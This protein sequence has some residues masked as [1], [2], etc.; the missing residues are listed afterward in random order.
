M[1][2]PQRTEDGVR[3]ALCFEAPEAGGGEG[4]ISCL[5]EIVRG[6]D[7]GSGS[8]LDQVERL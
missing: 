7:R 5:R 2:C 1:K 3:G 6:L 4:G 8:L